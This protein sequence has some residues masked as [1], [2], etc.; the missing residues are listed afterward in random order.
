[1]AGFL[2]IQSKI[3]I[4]KKN[5]LTIAFTFLALVLNTT[6]FATENNQNTTQ[7]INIGPVLPTSTISAG[8]KEALNQGVTE[9]VD[10][11]SKK[12]GFYK[13]TATK[14]LLPTEFNQVEKTLRSAGMGTFVDQSVK[15]INRAA[16]DAVT[17]AGPIFVKAITAIDF[18]DAM[19]I[20]LGDERSAT[21][22][23][24]KGT[25]SSLAAAFEPQIAA[26]LKKV[27]AD[28]AWESMIN[29]YNLISKN[30]VNANLSEYVTEQTLNGVY[31]MVGDKEADIRN[32]K[33]ARNTVVLKEVF[34]I[35][36][37]KLASPTKKVISILK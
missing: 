22:Y 32:N 9:G 25:E 37:S 3:S 2:S 33:S 11:L 13:N 15:L 1:M 8:L 26:S 12:N 20:L 24:K 4:M 31:T 21:T 23:L 29:K 27:G 6:L 7:Q 28:S 35:Q 14:I 10:N 5:K 18:N 19:G 16:E 36:D 17:S 34:A 30:K